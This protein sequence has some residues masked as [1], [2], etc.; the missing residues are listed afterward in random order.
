[1][2]KQVFKVSCV[3]VLT[4]CLILQVGCA[5]FPPPHANSFYNKEEVVTVR[6]LG[7]NE[8]YESYKAD[9]E[10]FKKQVPTL[11]TPPPPETKIAPAIA[12]LIPIVANLAFDYAKAQLK[13]EAENYVQQFGTTYFDA[14]WIKRI[15]ED[16]YTQKYYGFEIV[17]K[18][19]RYND[20][21][22]KEAEEVFKLVYGL[23][24]DGDGVFWAAPFYFVT[25]KTKA[26]VASWLLSKAHRIDTK[27][28]LALDAVW[29][30][31]EKDKDKYHKENVAKFDPLTIKGYDID[32]AKELR[33]SCKDNKDHTLC[34][35]LEGGVN[36]FPGVPITSGSSSVDAG[37]F[38]LTVLVTESD[39]AKTKSYITDLS[40][41]LEKN[42]D[43]AIDYIKTQIK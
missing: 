9:W 15:G 17:R 34:P 10:Q 30:E 32:E 38:W 27:V 3:L 39:T 29:I 8:I 2:K 13:K 33:A 43:K 26:K 36:S 42:K 11:K 5:S 20:Q 41:L 16:K 6:M 12:A 1:M 24:Q 28:E 21:T 35:P 40:D 4:S 18:A 7:W 25:K 19:K 37:K 14:F 31:K 22:Q 23:G